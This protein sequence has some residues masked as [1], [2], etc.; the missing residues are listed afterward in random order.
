MQS[1]QTH[2][3]LLNMRERY[4]E[5]SQTAFFPLGHLDC[6]Q[7]LSCINMAKEIKKGKVKALV[8]LLIK[9]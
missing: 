7:T 9:S 1:T 4:R 3:R 8:L 2:S 6:Q 5:I